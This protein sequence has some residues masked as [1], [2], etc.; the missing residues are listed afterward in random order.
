MRISWAADGEWRVRVK[1]RKALTSVA[2]NG[3]YPKL[4]VGR[5]NID[6]HGHGG[7]NSVTYEKGRGSTGA[8]GG[9]LADFDGEHGW[10]WRNRDSVPVTVTVLVK[11]ECAEFKDAS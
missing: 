8:E 10:F 11:G 2:D 7:G 6:L 3:T 1:F 4:H 5:V 9:I